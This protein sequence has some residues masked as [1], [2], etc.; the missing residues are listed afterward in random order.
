MM[1][2]QARERAELENFHKMRTDALARAQADELAALAAA[3][4]KSRED[5]DRTLRA[6]VE[7]AS[8]NAQEGRLALKTRQAEERERLSRDGPPKEDK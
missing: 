8:A 7:A 5:L 1:A 4:K 3:Q 2:R 6:D